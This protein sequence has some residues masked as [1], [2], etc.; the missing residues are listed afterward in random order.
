MRNPISS[1]RPTCVSSLV[2]HF[3]P[4]SSF[5]PFSGYSFAPFCRKSFV[6]FWWITQ[7]SIYIF[8]Q[9]ENSFFEFWRNKH[10]LLLF[11]ELLFYFF[12]AFRIKTLFFSFFPWDYSKFDQW[13]V[14]Q[15][16]PLNS[17]DFSSVDIWCTSNLKGIFLA[18]KRSIQ[19]FDERQKRQKVGMILV[20]MLCG[21]WQ[22]YERFFFS[23]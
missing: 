7:H 17:F 5:F 10:W 9:W 12:F 2:I 11:V 14:A 19:V 18:A 20:I 15:H 23:I 1:F 13:I 8:C 22:K 3:F 4:A 6:P 16:L 21:I